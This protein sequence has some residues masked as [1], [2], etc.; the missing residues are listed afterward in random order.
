MYILI[1]TPSFHVS[2]YLA[3]AKDVC[4]AQIESNKYKVDTSLPHVHHS[5]WVRVENDALL[6]VAEPL[7]AALEPAAPR[8]RFSSEGNWKGRDTG[9]R[10]P[11][12]PKPRG[13]DEAE[14]SRPPLP[15]A[16]T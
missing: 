16:E 13:R 3:P 9:T 12:I 1:N 11:S 4:G 5:L 2:L 10:P 14:P 8:G 7:A 15:A 6:L